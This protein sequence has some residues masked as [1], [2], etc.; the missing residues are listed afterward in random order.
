M[1]DSAPIHRHPNKVLPGYGCS[2]SDS[3]RNLFALAETG[4]YMPLIIA[5]H[6]Q[7][8]EGKLSSAAHCLGHPSDMNQRLSQVQFLWINS[9][10]HVCLF[11]SIHAP[12]WGGDPNTSEFYSR[13]S[14]SLCQCFNPPMILI[15]P[16]VE[17]NLI[18]SL[19]QGS[20]AQ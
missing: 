12:A 14:N 15:S 4:A 11:V 18:N 20:P 16:T 5:H 6:H 9:F 7:G 8:A 3:H 17:G 13:F 2:F 10:I 1:G 19:I